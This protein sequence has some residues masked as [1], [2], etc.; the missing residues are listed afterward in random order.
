MKQMNLFDMGE[1]SV[2]LLAP[3]MSKMTIEIT[4]RTLSHPNVQ[5]LIHSDEHFDVVIVEQFMNEALKGFA[6]HFNA[7]LVV[8]NSVG[9]NSWVN[10]TVGNPTPVSYCSE[11]IRGFPSKMTLYERYLNAFTYSYFQVINHLYTFPQQDKLLKNYFSNDLELADVMY[12]VSLVLLNS[13]PSTNQPVPYVPNMVDI[14]GYHVKPPKKLPDDLQEF[15]DN[16][17]HLFQ[18]GFKREKCF[19][20]GAKTTSYS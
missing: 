14:G 11:P 15:L 13:H 3:F 5:K 12:N 10:P 18:L 7:S 4:E 1:V 9:A 8:F 2:L 6:A 16:S 19:P 20:T 17:K